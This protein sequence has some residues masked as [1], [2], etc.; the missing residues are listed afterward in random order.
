MLY[1][2]GFYLL[3]GGAFAGSDADNNVLN[4]AWNVVLSER[5]YI[6]KLSCMTVAYICSGVY[7]LQVNINGP[8]YIT[9]IGW[10]FIGM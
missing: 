7:S 8:Q 2:S 9:E 6:W 3:I 1:S 5:F 4:F 10:L